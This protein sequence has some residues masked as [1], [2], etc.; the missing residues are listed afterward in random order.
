MYKY[1][2]LFF[3]FLFMF[4]VGK[5]PYLFQSEIKVSLG[6]KITCLTHEICASSLVWEGC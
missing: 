5:S 4:L 3:L 6:I 1:M 2:L